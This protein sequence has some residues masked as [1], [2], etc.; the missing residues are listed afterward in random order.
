MSASLSYNTCCG[1]LSLGS[2]LR[3]SAVRWRPWH[4]LMAAR[5]AC[6]Y[7]AP[8][9][10]PEDT[11]CRPEPRKPLDGPATQQASRMR[12]GSTEKLRSNALM[13]FLGRTPG[14]RQQ[15]GG[16]EAG[17]TARFLFTP[18]GLSRYQNSSRLATNC[19]QSS[20]IALSRT[21]YRQLYGPV[22]QQGQHWYAGKVFSISVRF[23]RAGKHFPAPQHAAR[24]E[25]RVSR[26][27]WQVHVWKACPTQS[28]QHVCNVSQPCRIWQRACSSNTNRV[29]R[30]SSS[31]QHQRQARK[32][33][34][35]HA[36][37]R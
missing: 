22:N 10:T 32:G 17:A 13:C 7:T 29:V 5:G 27:V 9:Y 26:A 12:Y 4:C 11:T 8:L 2:L 33:G 20:G 37:Q 23:V 24:P 16:Q 14:L 25:A 36:M 19:M 1:A 15:D 35:R 6:V 28:K 3:S 21:P 34:S 31:M 18:A 30:N